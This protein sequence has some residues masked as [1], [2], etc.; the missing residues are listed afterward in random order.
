MDM[1]QPNLLGE[2]PFAFADRFLADHAGQIILDPRTAIL[3]LIA[4]AYD[5]GATAIT[6][7]WPQ[8]KG[9]E[10]SV[11]DN[12]TGM[13]Q[14]EF[15]ERWKTLCYDRTKRQGNSVVFPPGVKSL[16]RTPFGKSGKGRF[17]PFCFSDSYS[18][19]TWKNGTA[20]ESRVDLNSE[21]QAPFK[22]QT[23]SVTQKKGH[24]TK[25]SAKIEKHF[26]S[27]DEIF[28]LIGSKFLVDPSLNVS[29]NGNVVKL[30]GLEGL[31][32]EEIT[33]PSHGVVTVHFIDS[34]E[35]YRTAQLRGITWWVNQRMV[36]E[37]SWD[38]LD[39]EGAYLDGRTEQAKRFSFVVE[40]NFMKEDVKADWSGFHTNERMLLVYAHV[41]KY[42]LNEIRGHLS[43]SRKESKKAALKNSRHLLGDLPTVSKRVL[44][45]FIDEIQEN[46]PTLSD[47]DLSKTVQVFA[48]LEQSRSGYDLLTQLALCSSD[49]L[50][51]WNSL[52]T[53]WTASNA[54]IVLDELQRRLRLI[55]KMQ[56]LVESPLADELHDL[57]PL[58]ERGLWIFGPEYEAVDF[59]SNRTL[60]QIIGKFLGGASY[61][62]PR[63][64]PDL[65][66]LPDSSIGAYCADAYDVTGEISGIRKVA[67]IE[68]KKGGF[69]VG[70]GELNQAMNYCKELKKGGRVQP[71][72]EIVAYVLGATLEDDLDIMNIGQTIS[73]I[74][75]VYQTVLRKAHQRTFNLQHKLK[76]SQPHLDIFDPEVDEAIKQTVSLFD[77]SSLRT[78]PEPSVD[79]STPSTSHSQPLN[80]F[81]A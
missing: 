24:G 65:V 60:S 19:L 73:V 59:R 43:G 51:R 25:V 78:K 54:E 45:H 8:E 29:V 70:Q 81:P 11:T 26:L 32:T 2:M 42:I 40:A 67:V 27:A 49:D 66:A 61:K 28:Q 12:G 39:D 79:P 63:T 80:Q 64:R 55:E 18:V 1:S 14:E 30:L 52:M 35:H 34:I 31:K 38:R 47:R 50:D 57:Q 71:T 36:G 37:P 69:C 72:T 10:F 74:P 68:L 3:E 56:S 46:C 15:E 13:N 77:S 5:A 48:K 76:E 21:G 23:G 44:G 58:F 7:Q 9:N 6:I 16:Q 17:A 53:Q 33:V 62:P 41:H 75:M 22:I 4:N 20:F